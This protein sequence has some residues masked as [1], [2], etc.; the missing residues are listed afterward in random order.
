ML[1]RHRPVLL[2]LLSLA[3]LIFGW[4]AYD[5]LLIKVPKRGVDIAIMIENR[6]DKLIGPLIISDKDKAS[7][8]T[9]A[10]VAP[11]ER[12]RTAFKSPFTTGENHIVMTD[13]DGESYMLVGYFEE[14]LG[15]WI[16]VILT[17]VTPAGLAGISRMKVSYPPSSLQW[18]PWP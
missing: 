15:G 1:Y 16:E 9:L 10:S 5:Q 17:E 14:R 7:A 11:L 6:T 2:I 13:G 3:L 4:L 18:Q 8:V 12:V